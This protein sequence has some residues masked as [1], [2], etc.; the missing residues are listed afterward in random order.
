MVWA[1]A[2]L[3]DE[4][5]GTARKRPVPPSAWAAYYGLTRGDLTHGPRKG[6]APMTRILLAWQ[7]HPQPQGTSLFPHDLAETDAVVRL[8]KEAS[9]FRAQ[10]TAEG[11]RF[12]WS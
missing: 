4:V 7:S 1:R 12:L 3:F 11:W 6:G 5:A 10:I 9:R 2:R 8:F